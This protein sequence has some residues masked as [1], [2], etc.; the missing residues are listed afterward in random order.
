VDDR[1]IEDRPLLQQGALIF[2]RLLDRL[3]NL[4][5]DAVLF[6]EM[7]KIQN[8][9]LIRNPLGNHVDPRKAPETGGV[10]Q[11]LFHQRIREREPLLQQVNP[12]HHLQRERRPASLGRWLVIDRPDQCMEII[13]GDGVLHLLKENLPPRLLLGV[14]LLVIAEHQL[15]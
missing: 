13:P 3:E 4:L 2:E 6:E 8:R 5:A 14:D 10:D 12:Q 7:T 9:G 15:K 11:H 1:G